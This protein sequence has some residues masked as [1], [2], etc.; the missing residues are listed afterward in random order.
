MDGLHAD[1]GLGR[2]ELDSR[3]E[4]REVFD[5]WKEARAR[6]G[7][8]GRNFSMTVEYG[9]L[10]PKLKPYFETWYSM[11]NRASLAPAE[12]ILNFW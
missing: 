12:L 5:A 8:C 6:L 9:K 7:T 2:R 3:G 1:P 11:A 4:G 10:I